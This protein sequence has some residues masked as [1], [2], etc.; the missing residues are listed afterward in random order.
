MYFVCLF[1][2]S[3]LWTLLVVFGLRGVFFASFGGLV[4]TSFVHFVVR[5]GRIFIVFP[6]RTIRY[7]LGRGLFVLYILGR[8]H[9][10][11]HNV[12]T[13]FYV[14]LLNVFRPCARVTLGGIVCNNNV[15]NFR[16]YPTCGALF[17]RAISFSYN[18]LWNINIF[19]VGVLGRGINGHSSIYNEGRFH[20]YHHGN[21]GNRGIEV[22]LLLLTLPTFYLTSQ[23]FGKGECAFVS[24]FTQRDFG[25]YF[26]VGNG[27]RTVRDLYFFEVALL[28][29]KLEGYGL[30]KGNI[31]NVGKMEGL[32]LVLR[33]FYILIANGDVKGPVPCQTYI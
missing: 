32:L 6:G 26:L 27:I 7:S 3:Y 30:G 28:L 31:G 16:L 8:V 14:R 21:K 1:S 10:L 9:Y 12:G 23:R 2:G 19:R 20:L 22:V 5:R 24:M 25:G 17:H 11:Y 4:F 29:S 33:L 15:G 13:R 18:F